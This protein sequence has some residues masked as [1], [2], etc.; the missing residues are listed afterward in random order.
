MWIEADTKVNVDES[1]STIIENYELTTE[2][3][4][5][6]GG[7][8]RFPPATRMVI[9]SILNCSLSA[10]KGFCKKREI[11]ISGLTMKFRGDY[12]EGVYKNMSCVISLPADFPEKYRDS[13]PRIFDACDVKKIIRNLPTIDLT[14][15]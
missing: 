13:V 4:V 5:A 9:A 6:Y 7:S 10:V 2:A 12:D 3:P 1:I 11:P 14:V 15:L 8:G